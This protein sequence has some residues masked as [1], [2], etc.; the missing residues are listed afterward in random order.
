MSSDAFDGVLGQDPAVALLRRHLAT[1]RGAG[2][3][4]LLGPDGVG[5]FL[6]AHR[7]ARE[8]LGRD[9]NAAARVDTLQHADLHVL[10]PSEGIKGVRELT[11][12]LQRQP[13]EGERN[14]VILR[15]LESFSLPALNALLKTL[16]E[17]PG[18]TAL[19]LIAENL[20]RLPET[21]VSRCRIVGLRRMDSAR[22]ADVLARAGVPIELAAE[23][24]GCPG[25][26]IS[27]HKG[28]LF[29]PAGRM[30][31][32]LLSPGSDPLGVMDKLIRKKS[33]E[34]SDAH[35]KRLADLLRIAG[36]R[37]RRELPGTE[38]VL[39]SILHA[40]GSIRENSNPGIV[41]AQL[42]L[43]TG[44]GFQPAKHVFRSR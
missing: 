21:I 44:L 23:S 30:H 16:E 10:S 36:S 18:G 26:A 42:L 2:S 17:P 3:T 27:W 15:D 12:S 38:P 25:R 24:E 32:L 28:G 5:R 1:G 39:R 34:D 6:M 9:A 13:V 37:V 14:V 31:D 20:D 29:E 41:F 43:E 40:L 22:C 33:D 4:L 19:F 35:R 8:I 11:A 7:C